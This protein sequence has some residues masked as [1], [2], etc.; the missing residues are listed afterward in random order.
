MDAVAW[1]ALI[2]AVLSSGLLTAVANNVWSRRRNRA[3]TAAVLNETAL[4]LVVPLKEEIKELRGEVKVYRQQ[5]GVLER[6]NREVMQQLGTHGAWDVLAQSLIVAHHLDIAP[7]PPL[8]PV[9]NVRGERT[10]AG[11]YDRAVAQAAADMEAEDDD[12]PE[13]HAHG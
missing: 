4:E 9:S 7:M 1:G 11:D 12:Q 5:V 13:R 2:A 3:D 6:R 10:R 8:Y